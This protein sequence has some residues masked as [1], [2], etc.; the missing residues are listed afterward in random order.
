MPTLVTEQGIIHYESFGRGR[1]VL[2]LHG[3]LGSWAL[4]RNTIEIL[5]QEFRTY[6]LDFFGF[7]ESFDRDSNFSVDH[8]VDSVSQ[9]MDRLGIVKAPLI[10]HSMGGTVSL[11]VSVR[12]PEKV[13]KTVVVGSPIQGDS[14][15]LLLKLSGYKG[16]ASIIWTTPSLLK[17]F[18][19]GYAYFLARDGGTLGRM[20]VD[21]VSKISADSFFQSIGTLRR[22]DL[23]GQIGVLKLPLLGIYGKHDR[24]VDPGQSQILKLCAPHSQIAWFEGSGHFPMMDEPERFHETIRQFLHSD[25]GAP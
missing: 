9:F 21:D 15:N 17:L 16:I 25:N 13:V 22:T 12:Y 4:W 14:L 8:Y 2:L 23:S 18:M 19:R 1:P 11:G 10:G 20:I 6:A 5:G 3:W 7:G 24:I